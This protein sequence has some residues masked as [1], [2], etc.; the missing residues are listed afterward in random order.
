MSYSFIIQYALLAAIVVAAAVWAIRRV[1]KRKRRGGCC[2]GCDACPSAGK[3]C[4]S[5]SIADKNESLTRNQNTK[6]AENAR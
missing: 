1:V 6:K 4:G 3:Q 2:T 5:C